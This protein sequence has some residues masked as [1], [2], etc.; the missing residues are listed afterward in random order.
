MVKTE[1]MDSL[2]NQA[3]GAFRLNM[4][5]EALEYANKMVEK[6]EEPINYRKTVNLLKEAKEK[7][8]EAKDNDQDP[9]DAEA[10]LRDAKPAILAKNYKD[11]QVLATRA[12]NA[13]KKALGEEVEEIEE[14]EEG[15]SEEAE[16][17]DDEGG[18]GIS[19][20]SFSDIMD[21][22]NLAKQKLTKS[23]GEEEVEKI[24]L[25]K[26]KP[27]KKEKS[28]KDKE[29]KPPKE[30]KPSKKE[31]PPLNIK[32]EDALETSTGKPAKKG[33][34]PRCPDCD[35]LLLKGSQFCNQCGNEMN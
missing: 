22:I 21:R 19:T 15:S 5:E 29:E 14:E 33:K 20:G 13:A 24:K 1:E 8:T 30:K 35:T 4:Y 10:F 27:P 17:G 32:D 18:T 23:V 7:I 12:I 3:I 9:G 16:D 28:P 6:A 34:N 31:K 25:K 11:A 2:L 26:E